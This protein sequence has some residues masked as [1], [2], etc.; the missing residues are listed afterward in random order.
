M[1]LDI[2]PIV[3]P[4]Y[5]LRNIIIVNGYNPNQAI[6]KK[7]EPYLKSA[8]DKILEFLLLRTE[9][10]FKSNNIQV[11]Y[12]L[13]NTVHEV[14]KYFKDFNTDITNNCDI[15]L[16]IQILLHKSSNQINTH[17]NMKNFLNPLP[18]G[19]NYKYDD[20]ELSEIIDELDLGN[21]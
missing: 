11:K 15:N 2:P 18:T 14:I 12:E 10:V 7:I 1:S 9:Q 6:K 4:N 5:I 3:C 8:I 20:N 19:S 16:K 17:F 21:L 13:S